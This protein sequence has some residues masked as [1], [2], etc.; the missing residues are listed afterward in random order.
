MTSENR[1]AEFFHL[2][3]RLPPPATTRNGVPAPPASSNR[4]A[5]V[6][7]AT[8]E[9]RSFHQQASEISKDIHG[10]STL[11]KELTYAI[12]HKSSIFSEDEE[13]QRI[14]QLV[15]H[16]KQAIENLNVRLETAQHTVQQQKK[17]SGTNSQ[18]QQEATNIVWGLQ[19]DFA[20]TAADFKKVLQ[21]RTETL[22]ETDRLQRQ[23][24]ASSSN[25]TD[26]LDE[27][28]DMSRHLEPPP[29]FDGNFP[30]L[31]LTSSLL[32]QQQ[33]NPSAAL[34][35]PHGIDSSATTSGMSNALHH[36]PYLASSSSYAGPYS[37]Y[38]S[39]NSSSAA[40]LTPL[41]IQRMEQEMGD[42]Q[43]LQL[44]PDSSYVQSR[45]EAMSTVEKQMVEL[46]SVFSKLA[47]LVHEHR[48]L[49]S[50]VED[51]VEDAQSNMLL[52]MN[53]LTDTLT[54]LRSNKAL[55]MRL[56]SVL[57]LFIIFFVVFFA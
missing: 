24:Y 49:V 2:V 42:Q 33:N 11:L 54:H 38:S 5:A 31:D 40:L 47:G 37:Q 9:L 43:M 10:T 34:P 15:L 7:K 26:A 32:Q 16:I 13:S 55:M 14:Q 36:N 39:G 45:A 18:I 1:S 53:A 19:S 17:R 35:R 21:Q 44:I 52:S 30:S 4:T 6:A 51:N 27:I 12:R 46:G 50:R 29:V 57:V 3:Q 20:E 56:F 28:P 48:E 8:H 23:M 41:D 25:G 22:Q